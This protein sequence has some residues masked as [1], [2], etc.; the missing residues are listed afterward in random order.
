ML[1]RTG[2][3]LI[4]PFGSSPGMVPPPANEPFCSCADAGTFASAIASAADT[5]NVLHLIQPR[6]PLSARLAGIT[7]TLSNR[8]RLRRRR[9]CFQLFAVFGIHR[10]GAAPRRLV[11]NPVIHA[12]FMEV[13]I[14]SRKQM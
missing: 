12:E 4:G 2:S 11:R 5:A 8:R 9:Q 10:F 1:P 6:N 3:T 7:R 14:G 13:G